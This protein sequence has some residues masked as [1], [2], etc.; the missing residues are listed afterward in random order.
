LATRYDKLTKFKEFVALYDPKG[1]F[2]NEFLNSNIYG[3]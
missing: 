3:G 2:R 1:K